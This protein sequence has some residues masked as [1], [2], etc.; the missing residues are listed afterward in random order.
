M[1]SMSGE[2]GS[3][4]VPSIRDAVRQGAFAGGTIGVVA[5]I[6]LGLFY[7]IECLNDLPWRDDIVLW[8]VFLGVLFGQVAM[9]W[10]AGMLTGLCMSLA[11]RMALGR[12]QWS[13][14][15]I[16]CASLFGGIVG[17]I[18]GLGIVTMIAGGRNAIGTGFR[19]VL[20][21]G[22]W[23]VLGAVSGASGAVRLRSIAEG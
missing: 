20:V 18:I 22:A 11:T 13:A 8:L 21:I 1:M 16:A 9:S 10:F 2:P 23:S 5:G 3:R 7:L 4:P 19:D 17:L 6:T 14:P 15:R 12:V